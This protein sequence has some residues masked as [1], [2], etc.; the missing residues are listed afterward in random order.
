MNVAFECFPGYEP[1]TGGV[2]RFSEPFG[3]TNFA[4]NPLEDSKATFIS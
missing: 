3:F 4:L 1:P 2:Q